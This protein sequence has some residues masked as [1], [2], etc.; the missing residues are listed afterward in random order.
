MTTDAG[1]GPKQQYRLVLFGHKAAEVGAV[2]LVLMVQGPGK[3]SLD[4]WIAI[5]WR[6]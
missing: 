4:H 2:C 5:H 3:V 1:L 6:K